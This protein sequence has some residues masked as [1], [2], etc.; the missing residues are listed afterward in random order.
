MDIAVTPNGTI[1]GIAGDIFEINTSAVTS[2]WVCTPMYAYGNNV[3]SA[4]LEALDNNY[5]LLDR[6]DSLFLIEIITGKA[7]NLGYIGYHCDGDFAFLNGK[8]YMSSSY[9]SLIKISLDSATHFITAVSS[10]GSMNA[11]VYSLFTTFESGSSVRKSLFAITRSSIFVVDTLNATLTNSCYL[12]QES[13]GAA[14][15]D[16]FNVPIWDPSTP[17]VFTPNGD[18]I[19]DVFKIGC[20]NSSMDYQLKIY[21]RYGVQVFNS[22]LYGQHWDGYT[23]AGIPASDGVYYYTLYSNGSVISGSITLLR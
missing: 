5:L 11:D 6:D 19:N 13:Y 18:G 4:G 2:K 3:P 23:S 20:V 22:I 9:A 14:S 17:N 16:G 12:G 15:V 10:I 7:T 8:L 21:N 1:Y